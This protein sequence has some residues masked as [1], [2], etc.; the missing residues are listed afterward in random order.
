[1]STDR[2]SPAEFGGVISATAYLALASNETCDIS[3]PPVIFRR[4]PVPASAWYMADSP[5]ASAMNDMQ[6]SSVHRISGAGTSGA[7]PPAGLIESSVSLRGARP[8]S[9]TN[10]QDCQPAPTMSSSE[11][12]TTI[13]SLDGDQHS[14]A[15]L[16][17]PCDLS[18]IRGLHRRL[19]PRKRQSGSPS[20]G[21][22]SC[23]R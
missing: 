22:A 2:R 21:R 13:A 15:T 14:A 7:Y 12:T 5:R 10:S 20:R 16:D 18:S 1:M 23:P 3:P 4:S 8:G 19:R 6:P 17:N 9:I 11:P